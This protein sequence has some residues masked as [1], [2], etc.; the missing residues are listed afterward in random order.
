MANPAQH[1]NPGWVSYENTLGDSPDI[2][3]FCG[4]VNSKTSI[5]AALWREGHL[6]HFGFEQSPGEMNDIG[7]ALLVNAIAYI[8]RF[9]H[10]QAIACARSPFAGAGARA[11]SSLAGW[12]ANEAYPLDYF[13]GAIAPELLHGV[14]KTRA[15]Y[16]EWFTQNRAYLHPGDGSQLVLDQQAK[17]LA[18]AWDQIEMFERAIAILRA[19]GEDARLA[20]A[21]LARYAPEG[22]GSAAGADA[23]QAWF[24]AN[25][26]YLFY[27][28]WCGYRW[29]IDPLAKQRRVETSGLRGP[30]RADR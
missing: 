22:P 5:G 9:T 4:G 2:E 10:D 11:R 16:R 14:S 29:Y 1:G 21:V 17:Q 20:G 3:I 18:I 26:P 12:L 15:A 30:A 7:R 8:A 28:E 23:W 13:A 6:L 19:G 27:S 25:R 24:D